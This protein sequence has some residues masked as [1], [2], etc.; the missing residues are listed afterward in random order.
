[1]ITQLSHEGPTASL[2]GG[3]VVPDDEGLHFYNF[4]ELAWWFPAIG[5]DVAAMMSHV[6]THRHCSRI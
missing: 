2:P 5:T 3:P 1:M 4:D 6:A